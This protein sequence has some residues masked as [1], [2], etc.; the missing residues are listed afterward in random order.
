M[1]KD[2]V[3]EKGL[4]SEKSSREKMVSGS[5]WMTGGSILSRLLGALYIIPWMAWMGNQEVANSANALYTI[6]ILRTHYS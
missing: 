2:K 1:S 3:E 4:V 6:G 5:A